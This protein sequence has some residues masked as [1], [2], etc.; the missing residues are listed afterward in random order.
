M[1]W[2]GTVGNFL[3]EYYDKR[4]TPENVNSENPRTYERENQ[5]WISNWNTYFLRSTDYLRLKNLEIG[6]TVPC[7]LKP[8]GI[9]KLRVFATGQN[10]FTIDNVPGDPENTNKDYN[11]FPLRKY[12]NF[13]VSVTF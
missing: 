1:T 9:S 2:S 8:Y 7:D 5:Y 4:W 6:Y 13:G 11:A 10:L 12:Y 3:K